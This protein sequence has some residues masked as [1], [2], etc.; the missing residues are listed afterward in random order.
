MEDTKVGCRWVSNTE[1]HETVN[2]EAQK[3]VMTISP[4]ITQLLLTQITHKLRKEAQSYAE[5]QNK[6][7]RRASM[8]FIY[9]LI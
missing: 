5:K 2:T 8:Q 4:L 7:P 9:M 1:A 3:Y 6:H